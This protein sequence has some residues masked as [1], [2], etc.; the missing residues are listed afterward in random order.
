MAPSNKPDEASTK[1]VLEWV[2]KLFNERIGSVKDLALFLIE[3]MY[4]ETRS[5]AALTLL[6][7]GKDFKPSPVEGNKQEIV[8]MSDLLDQKPGVVVQFDESEN[9]KRK[10]MVKMD[11][12]FCNKIF[13]NCI[14]FR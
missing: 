3:K 13:T 6:S 4:V 14:I 7:S 9:G 12:L 10:N 1:I 5:S 8:Q 2:E 11:E